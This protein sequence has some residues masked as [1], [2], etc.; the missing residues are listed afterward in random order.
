MVRKI[1]QGKEVTPVRMMRG[2][3]YDMH[4]EDEKF[5]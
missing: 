2:W 5:L 1:S 3:A 4:E